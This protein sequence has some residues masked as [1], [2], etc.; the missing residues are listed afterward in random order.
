MALGIDIVN[1]GKIKKITEKFGRRFLERIFTKNEIDHIN[2][3]FSYERIAGIFAAKEAAAKC[4][5][6]GFGKSLSFKDVEIIY[7][8]KGKPNMYINGVYYDV[9]VSHHI[10]YAVAVV[11]EAQKATAIG[12]DKELVKALKKRKLESHKGDFGKVG[13][14]GA[15]RGMLGSVYLACNAA[16]RS[17]AGLVYAICEESLERDLSVKFVEPIVKSFSACSDLVRH[18]ER[19][20]ALAIGP[21]FGQSDISKAVFQ[22][23]LNF[24]GPLVIDADGLN[25]LS[26]TEFQQRDNL[27][28]TPHTGE[29]SRLLGI[30]AEKIEQ[31]RN[32]YA[33]QASL[34]YGATVIL[35]GHRTVICNGS[36]IYVNKTGN[37]GM[38]TAGSGDVLTG[39]LTAFLGMGIETFTAAKLAVHIHGLAG[40]LAAKKFGEYS[41]I[42]GDIINSLPE[43]IS[44][45]TV[46]SIE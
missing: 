23:S 45:I 31:D 12:I 21:G 4:L 27:I 13:I 10:E 18:I 11:A 46:M 26:K 24:Q 9:S 39:I 16:L 32:A 30:S 43:L 41:M 29:M 15:S 34:L 33:I 2:E 28:L 44:Q 14:I 20:D 7:D 42:A 37:P 3:S 1:I 25:I 5:G 40:D 6:T 17:G 38:A 36:E 8:D 19:L 35:K 22:E